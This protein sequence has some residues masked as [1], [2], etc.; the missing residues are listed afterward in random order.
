M[1]IIGSDD[2]HEVSEFHDFSRLRKLRNL[3]RFS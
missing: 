2:E 3:K 1:A